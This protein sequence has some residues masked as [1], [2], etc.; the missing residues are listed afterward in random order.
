MTTI[1]QRNRFNDNASQ[2]FSTI[3]TLFFHFTAP[4]VSVTGSVT[5]PP[6]PWTLAALRPAALPRTASSG[7][8]D[9]CAGCRGPIWSSWQPAGGGWPGG[10]Q[11]SASA[12]LDHCDVWPERLMKHTSGSCPAL[13][14]YEPGLF[15]KQNEKGHNTTSESIRV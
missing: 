4:P 12:F 9:T 1:F 6:C 7:L 3:Q 15:M 11:L 13:L 2:S 14:W 5:P 10:T 8:S